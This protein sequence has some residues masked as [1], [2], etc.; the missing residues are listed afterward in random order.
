MY[1]YCMD[2]SYTVLLLLYIRT[3]V[4]ESNP[5]FQ[6]R[7]PD[8]FFQPCGN[9]STNVTFDGRWY[10]FFYNNEF[11]LF[12]VQEEEMKQINQNN[13]TNTNANEVNHN[14]HHIHH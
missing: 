8:D 13:H 7:I 9:N 3:L 11:L 10:G 1:I 2:E 4:I 12:V 6:L 5:F 14:Y